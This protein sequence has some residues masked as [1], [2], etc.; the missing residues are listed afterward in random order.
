MDLARDKGGRDTL[1]SRGVTI[2][3]IRDDQIVWGR[4][5]LEETERQGA[6]IREAVRR[7]TGRSPS[8]D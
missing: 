1:D 2:W 8:T 3:G 5:Y 6:D 4:L 7:I